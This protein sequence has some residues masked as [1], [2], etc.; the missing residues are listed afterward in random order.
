MGKN[1]EYLR[2]EVER[3]S[4]VNL[5][6]AKRIADLERELR[7]AREKDTGPIG[8]QALQDARA[9]RADLERELREAREE[10]RRLQGWATYYVEG[11]DRYREALERLLD[12]GDDP[13]P[14]TGRDPTVRREDVAFARRA[15]EEKP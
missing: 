9:E 7:E 12:N 11:R 10:I 3:I 14:L 5:Q 1:V 8:R 4:G 6:Q 13:H 15:L 2:G